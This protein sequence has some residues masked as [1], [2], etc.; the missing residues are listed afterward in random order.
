[1]TLRCP[2]EGAGRPGDVTARTMLQPVGL[3]TGTKRS[4][5]I[6]LRYQLITPTPTAPATTTSEPRIGY[7]SLAA[8]SQLSQSC[9]HFSRGRRRGDC[10]WV[11][12]LSVERRVRE[13]P[14]MFSRQP[15]VDRDRRRADLINRARVLS[16][17]MVGT[18]TGRSGRRAR[19][20]VW[21]LSSVQSFGLETDCTASC[22]T[23]RRNGM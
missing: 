15:D 18:T 19:W 10:R 3:T 7:A 4:S 1:M 5:R 6:C 9:R 20:W 2:E 12:I 21:R 8:R 22:E 14:G 16:A 13:R 11:A 17:R 23:S